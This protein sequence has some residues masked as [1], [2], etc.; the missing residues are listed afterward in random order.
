MTQRASMGSLNELRGWSSN[1]NESN[2]DFP[3]EFTFWKHQYDFESILRYE[4]V[5]CDTPSEGSF[6]FQSKSKEY[7]TFLE[8]NCSHR[9]PFR[10]LHYSFCNMTR[11]I[12]AERCIYLKREATVREG[13]CYDVDS[14]LKRHWWR[15]SLRRAWYRTLPYRI[16]VS[17]V[18][19][20]AWYIDQRS[21]CS[22]G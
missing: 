12:L 6:W 20:S 21:L 11:H 7:E 19:R 22:S 13:G 10:L 5:L 17:S 16:S 2:L 3:I 4:K 8:S 18:R 9:L 1:L 14:Y 15:Q